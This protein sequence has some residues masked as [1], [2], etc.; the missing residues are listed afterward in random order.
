MKQKTFAVVGLVLVI[1]ILSRA[2]ALVAGVMVTSFYG[3]NIE[4]SSYSF[5]LNLTN[6]ITTIIGTALTTAVIPMYT[7]LNETKGEKHADK[8]VSNIV[9]ITILLGAL[10][11]SICMILAPFAAALSGNGETAFLTFAVRTMM[12]AIIFISLYYIF[13]GVLQS[14]GKFYL[15][16]MVSIPSSLVN[17]LYILLLSPYFGVAGLVCSTVVGFFLQAFILY[18]PIVKSGKKIVPKINFKDEQIKTVLKITAPVLIGVCAYQINLL[19]NSSIAYSYNG[20]KYIVLS[21]MQN[22]GI[23]IVMTII[24]A[25]AS[26]MYPKLTKLIVIGDNDNFNKKFTQTLNFITILMI[27]ITVGFVLLSYNLIDLVYGYGKFTAQ[28]VSMGSVIFSFYSLGI[29]GNGFKE[30]VD[31]AYYAHKITKPSAY[32]GVFIMVI[33]IILSLLLVKPYGFFGI[34]IAYSIASL[35]GGFAIL[36]VFANKYKDFK[37]K[38]IFNTLIKCIIAAIL[39]GGVVYFINMQPVGHGKFA[40]IIKTGLAILSGALSYGIFLV[41]LKCNEIMEFVGYLKKHKG[42]N[43]L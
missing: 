38:P 30:I 10:I 27:P 16:A 7:E 42:E 37:L 20:E 35:C 40:L 26:V 23:Q 28:D 34:A 43:K 4:T 39:M 25:V 33:N 41:M 32:N 15:A 13:S 1:N 29:L 31:R 5:A 11:C 9:G 36:F 18:L 6:I 19:T 3:T 17:I 21:N 12:P 2:C 8:F 14:N 24:L 22:L